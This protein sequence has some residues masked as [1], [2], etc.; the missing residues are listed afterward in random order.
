VL[1][2]DFNKEK[3]RGLRALVQKV[4]QKENEIFLVK[5]EEIEIWEEVES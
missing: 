2:I 5:D 4:N 1:L 3:E